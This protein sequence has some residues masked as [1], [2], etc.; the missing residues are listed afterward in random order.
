VVGNERTIK[1]ISA[2]EFKELQQQKIKEQILAKKISQR[3]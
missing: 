3:Y 2:Q 1:T